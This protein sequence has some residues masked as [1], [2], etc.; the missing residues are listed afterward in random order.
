[1]LRLFNRVSRQARI[2]RLR[3]GRLIQIESLEQRGLLSAPA[4][5]QW[6]MAPQLT[7]DPYNDGQ[8]SLP[9]TLAY[10]NPPGGY[11]VMLNGSRTTGVGPRTTFTWTISNSAGF[12]AVVTGERPELSLQQGVYT[13]RLEVERLRGT[14]E[15]A[16]A[17]TQINVKDVLIASIGDSIASGEGNPVVPGVLGLGVT[18][19]YSP[20]AAM[21]T[22]NANAHRSTVAAPAQFALALQRQDPHEAVT[23]VSVAN[24]GAS[25]PEGLLGPMPSI[26]DSTD[27]LPAEIDELRSIIG[28]HPIN[29]LTISV[30]ADDIQFASVVEQLIKNTS[31][32]G[33]ALAAIKTEVDTNL[34]MLPSDYAALNQAVRSLAPAHVM[35]TDYPD[36]TRNQNGQIAPFVFL[37]DTIISATDAKFALNNIIIPLNTAIRNAAT[38]N[39]WAFVDYSPDFHTHGYPS[40]DSWIRD[41]NDSFDIEGSPDGAF[42]PNAAGQRDIARRLLQTYEALVGVNR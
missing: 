19:A 6:R 33:P 20:D 4:V 26:G 35:I 12:L 7:P 17:T 15:P 31:G 24:S 13:A 11:G 40:T 2:R 25:I 27:V 10:V 1:M 21:N 5:I 9:N 14:T 32:V 38:A 29:A 23:F 36:L 18:W 28:T 22:E 8:I 41:L 3:R 16:F 42:H 30:G 37:G 34:A 39:K